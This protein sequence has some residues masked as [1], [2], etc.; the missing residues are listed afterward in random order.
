LTKGM[1][2]PLDSIRDLNFWVKIPINLTFLAIFMLWGSIMSN[3]NCSNKDPD[4]CWFHRAVT[5]GELDLLPWA[6]FAAISG[7]VFLLTSEYFQWLMSSAPFRFLGRISYTLYLI[8]EF[9]IR[10]W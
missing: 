8:H 7:F 2:R 3:G 9:I 5:F 1:G 6:F 4:A 10:G